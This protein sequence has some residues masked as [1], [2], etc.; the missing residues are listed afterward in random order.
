MTDAPSRGAPSTVAMTS[1]NHATSFLANQFA[2]GDERDTS[3]DHQKRLQQEKRRVRTLRFESTQQHRTR[4]QATYAE[5]EAHEH[6]HGRQHREFSDEHG[7]FSAHFEVTN[8]E[9]F[10]GIA[11]HRN[12]ALQPNDF[13]VNTLNR[14]SAKHHHGANTCLG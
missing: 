1:D 11:H 4:K 9:R 5:P 7:Y 14:A 10:E 8:E 3:S 6:F 13:L 12:D 2:G